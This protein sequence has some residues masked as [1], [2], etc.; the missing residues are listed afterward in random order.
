MDRAQQEA[1]KAH[2]AEHGWH[3]VHAVISRE[4]AA[5]A[6]EKLWGIAEANAREGYSCYLPGIDPNASMVRILTPLDDA[7]FRD[8]IRNPTALAM[9]RAVVGEE[10]VVANCTANIARPGSRPMALH[11]DLAFILPEPW[12]HP[13]S[14]NV[15]WC[16]T[17]VHRDNGATQYVPG[18]H[19]WRT[20]ADVPAD[21]ADRL[22]SFEAE[23]G[24]II[25]TDG[26][27][28][29][30]SGANVTPDEDRAL[31]FGYYSAAFLR[32]MINWNVALDPGLQA[33]LS[34][35]LRQLLGLNVMA[36]NANPEQ[37]GDWKGM[38]VGAE[39]ALADFRRVRAGL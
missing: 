13:W 32:P 33:K 10:I 3:I 25:V 30:T 16:L 4:A 17:D 23:A 29:H 24:S 1:A 28:W 14:V 2:L 36:N 20:H 11:A 9:A 21:A 39:Q 15:I 22:V 26:R 37:Q 18:S 31:L 6:V 34:P 8:L 7:I 19:R 35:D 38:P 27:L 12:I 5:E